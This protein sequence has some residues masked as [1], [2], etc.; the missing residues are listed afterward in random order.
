MESNSAYAIAGSFLISSIILAASLL[1][2]TGNVNHSLQQI[3]T[4]LNGMESMA[5]LAPLAADT[6]PI[7]P[8]IQQTAPAVPPAQAPAAPAQPGDL[9]SSIKLEGRPSWGNENA[10]VTIVEYSD[11]QCPFCSRFFTQ[12]EAPLGEEY[13]NTGKVRFVYKHFPLRSIHPNAQKASEATECAFDQGKFW[14]MHDII[15][16]N[17]NA[18]G[19]D[20]LKG[21]AEELGLDIQRFNECLDSGE[22]EAIVEADLQEGLAHGVQGTPAFF[23]NNQFVSGAQPYTVFQQILASQ[24]V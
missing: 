5:A 19:V 7:Q 8:T 13:V 14:E 16:N 12:T 23:V 15:F 3:S 10:P 1:Y 22:K 24:G 2:A 11:F 6:V 18:I 17:Q 9:P 4:N 21:Y 20:A